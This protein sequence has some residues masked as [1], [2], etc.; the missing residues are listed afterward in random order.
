MVQTMKLILMLPITLVITLFTGYVYATEY[1]DGMYQTLNAERGRNGQPTN[2]MYI[3]KGELNSQQVIAM[4]GCNPGCTSIV[5][6]YQQEPSATLGREIYFSR[7]GIYLIQ[8]DDSTWITTLPDSRLGSKPWQTLRYVNVFTRQGLGF[9]L[10]QKKATEF[11]LKQSL[12]IMQTGTL[13]AMEH[14]SGNYYAAVPVKALGKKYEKLSVIF[15]NNPKSISTTACEHCPNELFTYLAD[16]SGITGQATYGNQQGNLVFDVGDGV[17][18]WAQFKGDYG[19]KRW[20]K[21]HHFNVY[22]KDIGY[23]RDI[24]NEKAQQDSVDNLMATF[25][26]VTKEEMDQ[27]KSTAMQSKIEQQRLPQRGLESVKLEKQ[28]T[29]ASKSWAKHYHWKETIEY[30]YFSGVNWNIKHHPLTGLVTGR[31]IYGIIVLRRDDGLCSFHYAQF[32]Q[33]FNGSDFSNTHMI[34]L[35]PG[36]YKLHCEHI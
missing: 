20:S 7:S 13:V 28:I 5:Y 31:H 21:H 9:S 29:H 36:Q 18:I 16:E 10:S 23:I 11:A 2:K 15:N 35:T 24:R 26:N 12:D 34:G 30:S 3:Q 32:G 25:A 1:V 22:A 4:A 8:Y 6:T 14:G 19:N 17:L 27:R 33:D